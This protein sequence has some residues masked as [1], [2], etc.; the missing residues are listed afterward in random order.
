MELTDGI[1]TLR[2]PVEAD[3]P[4]IVAGVRS[5]QQELYPWLPWATAD[6]DLPD[7]LQWINLQLDP[8]PHVIVDQ[9]NQVVGTT[10]LN[11]IDEQHGRANLGYWLRT[12]R[13]G[14]GFATRA[15]SLLAHHGLTTLGFHRIEIIMSVEN[16][17]SRA[18]ARR[19]GAVYE[20]VLRNRLLLHGRL[21]DAHSYSIIAD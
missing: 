21:H 19:S 6:Y 14:N 9:T 4:E 13:S 11:G 20:G 15:T 7:A 8:H 10:G 1:V 18:V 16:E 17:P 12:D 3:A 5:S 2:P